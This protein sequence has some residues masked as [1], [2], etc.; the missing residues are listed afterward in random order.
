MELELELEPTVTASRLRE[1]IYSILDG[2]LETG[3][4]VLI[5][6]NGR[7]L[8]IVADDAPPDSK[9]SRLKKRDIIIGDSDDLVHMDWTGEWSEL[10]PG[11]AA[12]AQF[13]VEMAQ[14]ATVVV[15]AKAEKAA[16]P[17]TMAAGVGQ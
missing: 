4:P 7:R 6:R 14:T 8:R 1:N 10:Q 16:K 15:A 12:A 13:P 17:K 9:L 5:A 11:I 2:V 3:I